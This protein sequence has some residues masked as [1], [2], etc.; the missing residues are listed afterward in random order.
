[1][2]PL[3][4]RVKHAASWILWKNNWSLF[5]W[6]LILPRALKKKNKLLNAA[7]TS[8]FSLINFLKNN[9][10]EKIY[11][12]LDIWK[13]ELEFFWFKPGIDNILDEGCRNVH[14]EPTNTSKKRPLRVA[15]MADQP[16]YLYTWGGKA[17]LMLP[18]RSLLLNAPPA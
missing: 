17:Y 1:M 18:R 6:K 8:Q 7:I 14:K 9:T 11:I 16:P 15:R 5:L 2:Y 10:K 12:Y 4:E 13:H 3:L